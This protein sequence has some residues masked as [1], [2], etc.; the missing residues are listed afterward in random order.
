MLSWFIAGNCTAGAVC[1]AAVWND[2]PCREG[3]SG[4]DTSAVCSS[5]GLSQQMPA[6]AWKSSCMFVSPYLFDLQ[7]DLLL[8]LSC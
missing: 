3:W 5:A 4:E 7:L 2:Q 8:L 1:Q 6:A